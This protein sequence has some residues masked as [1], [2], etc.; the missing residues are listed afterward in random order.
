[1]DEERGLDNGG[2]P[3]PIHKTLWTTNKSVELETHIE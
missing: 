2:G 1:M 3:V